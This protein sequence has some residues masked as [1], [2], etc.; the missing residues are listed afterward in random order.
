MPSSSPSVRGTRRPAL[1]AS[2]RARSLNGRGERGDRGRVAAGGC[3]ANMRPKFA[4]S[5][6]PPAS[7]CTPTSAAPRRR[8]GSDGGPQPRRRRLSQSRTRSGNRQALVAPGRDPRLGLPPHRGGV[9]DGGEQQRRRDGDRAA[10]HRVRAKR[11]SSRAASSSRSAAVFASLRSWPSAA[12]SCARSARRTSRALPTTSAPSSPN[13]GALFQRPY[14]QLSR[15]RL[16]ESGAAAGARRPGPEAQPSGDRRHRQRCAG[17]LR[18]I[19]LRG[20]TRGAG[21]ASRPARTWSC[22]AATSCSAVRKPASSRA[23][24]NGSQQIEKDP[25]MRAFRLDKMTLAAL[26]ATLRLYLERGAGVAR[27]SRPAHAGRTAGRIARRAE[28]LG[29]RLGALSAACQR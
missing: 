8:R 25:L 24:R 14:E 6:T 2:S 3:S 20:R 15:H 27:N 29:E 5:S 1:A 28:N 12:R 16:H 9:G 10:G 26:E 7:S 17:R 23:R 22:S 11:S 13:T 4:A 19:R 21:R 18:A